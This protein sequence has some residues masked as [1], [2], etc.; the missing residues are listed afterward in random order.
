VGPCL[1]PPG[2]L[3]RL[4]FTALLLGAGLFDLNRFRVT[5]SPI[6]PGARTGEPLTAA[7]RSLVRV[8]AQQR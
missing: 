7:G 3:L 4:P 1:L 2:E 5:S 8:R 6:E